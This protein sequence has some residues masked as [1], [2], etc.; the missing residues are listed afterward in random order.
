[1]RLKVIKLIYLSIIILIVLRLGFW[2]II[3]ADEMEARGESQRMVTH[4][5]LAP[6]GAILFADGSMLASSQPSYLVYAQPKVLEQKILQDNKVSADLISPQ[7]LNNNIAIKISDYK[8][9]FASQTANI[10]WEAERK[11]SS[12]S[13]EIVDQTVKKE[14]IEEMEK[15]I[16]DKL[17]QN[18][19]WVNLGKKINLE[20]KQ[21]LEKLN[22]TGLGFQE[23]S[24]RFYPEGSSS[25]HLLGF[26]GFDAFGIDTGYFGLEGFYGGELKGKKGIQTLER[27][28]LGV[29]ILIGK[30]LTKEPKPGKTLVLN[31]D[32][33]VQFIVEQNLAKSVE[34]YGAR[35]ASAVVMEPE[36]GKILAMASY[37]AYNP[38]RP[39][40]YPY[41]TYRNPITADGYEP[42]STFK[43]LVMAAGINEGVVKPETVCDICAGPLAVSNYVIRTWNNQYN[44][45]ATMSDVIIHSDNIGMV[46]VS[47]KLG[48]EKMYDYIKKFGFGEN[49]GIDLQDES[50]PELRGKKDWKEIDLATASFGQ[51][52]SVTSLQ[53]VR[54]VS[55]IANGGKLMEPQVVAEIRDEKD[56]SE[57][58]PGAMDHK[59]SPK[60][61]SEPIT[62]ETAETIKQMMV[63]AVDEGESKFYKPKGYKI[64][65][66]T[67][68]AQIPVA[69]HYDPTKTIASFVGFAPADKPKFVML[70]RFVEPSSSIFGA[71]TAAPTF[72]SI[73]KE[74][75]TYYNIAPSEPLATKN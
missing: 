73:A 44:P 11:E 66:K 64:A 36:T 57:Q 48:F 53:V 58:S 35:G 31:V 33:A 25:A 60:V 65:G 55:A 30:F 21:K 7:A 41:E 27:D 75:F 18:L 2:Q 24:R 52:I 19:F 34:K 62:K 49:T 39:D 42:G 59:I 54:A 14:E 1:M 74:L 40:L 43:V 12:Q 20:V 28:A 47:R 38:A 22:L 13:A 72:F 10:F 8:R 70:V 16:F 15:G 32:R 45:S 50:S 6:R 69:G 71:E 26:V 56:E 67:G 37:P 4:Q 23:S 17:N 29:P 5:V 9:N 51:G 68:T 3:K 61:I 63:R 46:F